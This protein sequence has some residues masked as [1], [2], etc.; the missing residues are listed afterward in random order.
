MNRAAD[1]GVRVVAVADWRRFTDAAADP[2]YP[3]ADAFQ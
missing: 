3:G 1:A 2:A